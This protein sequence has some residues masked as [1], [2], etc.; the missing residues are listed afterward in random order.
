MKKLT[1]FLL[2]LPTVCFAANATPVAISSTTVS[3][4]VVTVNTA[5]AHNLSAANGGQASCL[6]APSNVCGVVV[7][8][9]TSTQFTL[10]V[11]STSIPAPCSASC[12]TAVPAPQIIILQTN[13]ISQAEVIVS[14]VLWI[15]TQQPCPGSASSVWR[16]ANGSVGATTQQIQ[17][18]NAGLIVEVVR[19][20]TLPANTTIG[21]L[22]TLLQNDYSLQQNAVA[23]NVQPCAIY[24][25][26]FDS[27]GW[28]KQ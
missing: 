21:A 13:A 1:L 28:A 24:G 26:V 6:S 4:A 5:A 27:V 15:T 12:G 9:P 11:S 20:K 10:L 17:A 19:S 2:L 25:Q 3:G 18:I 16:S 7:T 14:Y 8:A 23:T 22:Q